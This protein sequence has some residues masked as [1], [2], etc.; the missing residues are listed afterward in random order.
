MFPGGDTHDPGGIEDSV[1]HHRTC[2]DL[3]AFP[4]FHSLDQ[5][6]S[7]A[8]ETGSPD[9]HLPGATWTWSPIWQ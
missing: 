9:H 1:E 7:G 4:D 6:G 2:S 3:S 5:R 8:D